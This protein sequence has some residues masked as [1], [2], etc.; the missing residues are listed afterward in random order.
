MAWVSKDSYLN[1]SEQENNANISIYEKNI[2]KINTELEKLN[3]DRLNALINFNKKLITSEEYTFL[4]E[5]TTNEETRLNEQINALNDMIKN[6]ELEHKR[7][8]I[9][10]LEKCL[11]EYC[12]LNV[13]DKHKL[14][15]SIIDKI[16]YEKTKSGR[17]DEEALSSFTLE[18]FLKL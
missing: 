3:N 8:A 10:I 11:N 9:P 12:N 6:N 1:Q 18:I 7:K 4:K 5:Y 14:L 15:S 13:E 16:V 2:A 17:W